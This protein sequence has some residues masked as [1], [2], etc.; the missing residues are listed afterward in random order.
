[1]QVGVLRRDVIFVAHRVIGA[2]GRIGIRQRV[3]V[4]SIA[5]PHSCFKDIVNRRWAAHA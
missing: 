4:P 3:S 5:V 1:M 2:M